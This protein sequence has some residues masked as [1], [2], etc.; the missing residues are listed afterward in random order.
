M[1]IFWC[2]FYREISDVKGYPWQ[3]LKTL[4]ACFLVFLGCLCFFII[5]VK[6]VSDEEGKNHQNTEIPKN[7]VFSKWK[8]AK[9]VF[10]H[11]FHVFGHFWSIFV[12]KP[13]MFWKGL[14]RDWNWSNWTLSLYRLY[15]LRRLFLTYF[16]PYFRPY[17]GT[18]F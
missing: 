1:T 9:N 18:Y 15:L 8:N 12:K 5:P 4:K 13:E 2:F 11:V 7:T 14:V 17:F 6:M 10:F 16:R 3:T